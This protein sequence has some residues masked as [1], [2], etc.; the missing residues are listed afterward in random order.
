VARLQQLIPDL[1]R[2]DD[3]CA[4]YLIKDG[5]RAIAID[6]GSGRWLDQL[7]ALGIKH[8]DHVLITHLHA[9]QC[10]GLLGRKNSPFALH[11][12][13]GQA[14][15]PPPPWL[16]GGCPTNYEPPQGELPG[17]VQDLAGNCHFFWQGRRLRCMDVD[18]KVKCKI[19]K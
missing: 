18:S 7:P 3:T 16:A 8:L 10:S 17:A 13:A 12:P 6:F 4:V 19:R 15:W 1:W 2:I 11:I 9:D 14:S 5:D